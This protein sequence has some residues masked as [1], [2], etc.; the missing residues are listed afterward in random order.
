[1]HF[2]IYRVQVITDTREITTDLA[3][4]EEAALEMLQ[5]KQE[6]KLWYFDNSMLL[7]I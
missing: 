5:Q 4:A 7:S 3:R 6:Q 1:M 2:K